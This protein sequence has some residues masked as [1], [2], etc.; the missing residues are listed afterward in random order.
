MKFKPLTNL[1]QWF[2][3]SIEKSRPR[4]LKNSYLIAI[5]ALILGPIKKLVVYH[6][7]EMKIMVREAQ[8]YFYFFIF[9]NFLFKILFLKLRNS[10]CYGTGMLS[11]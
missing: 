2:F 10:A 11:F 8:F 6:P 7:S 5:I 1:V 3:G 9:F 4:S